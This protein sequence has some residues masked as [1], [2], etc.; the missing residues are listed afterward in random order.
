M[1]EETGDTVY[2]GLHES[3]II[4]RLYTSNGNDRNE[5]VFLFHG[6]KD[7]DITFCTQYR[8]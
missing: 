6:Q 2:T 3:S 5:Y 1:A 7:I 4:F 8:T